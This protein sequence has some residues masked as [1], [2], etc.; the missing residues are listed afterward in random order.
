[1][2]REMSPEEIE[3][4]MDSTKPMGKDDATY[5]VSP[6]V[7]KKIGE[8]M[9]AEWKTGLPKE[10]GVYWG[11]SKMY[12]CHWLIEVGGISAYVMR[13]GERMSE[14]DYYDME[15]GPKVELLDD[16]V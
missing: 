12:K 15:F 13:A 2:K 1:M 5:F 11:R 6:T 14:T 3:K 8:A 7:L 4:L 16:G 9:G 10:P